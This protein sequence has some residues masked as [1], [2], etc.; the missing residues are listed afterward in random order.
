M[1]QYT[2]ENILNKVEA[3]KTFKVEEGKLIVDGLGEYVL[4]NIVD[5]KIYKTVGQPGRVAKK[6]VTFTGLTAGKEYVLSFRVITPDQYLA[7]YASPNWQ[8]FGKPIVVGFNY[9]DVASL[10]E[11]IELAIPEGNK[12]FKVAAGTGTAV[13]LEATTKYMDFDKVAVELVE[14]KENDTVPTVTVANT[15]ERIAPFAT[16]EWIIENLRFPTYPNIR[17]NSAGNMPT[18]E[19]YDELSFAYAVPRVGLGGLSGVGQG[20]TAV[21]RHIFYVPAGTITTI[22]NGDAEL[23]DSEPSETGDL[24]GRGELDTDNE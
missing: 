24:D 2:K 21:T 3:G 12:Y 23:I 8:V 13:V 7:E 22:K 14:K 20:L 9:K 15:Q 16:K 4:A 1:F 18:A 6:T 17:Y 5:Q 19:L 10:V 11:A